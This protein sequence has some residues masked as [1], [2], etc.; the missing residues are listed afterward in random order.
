MRIG[1]FLGN[2]WAIVKENLVA[3]AIATLLMGVIS[4]C[5]L[6]I[7]MGPMYLG[8]FTMCLKGARKEKVEI[9]DVFAGFQ[10]IGDSI[11]LGLI[12]LVAGC[13]GVGTLLL[14]GFTWSYLFMSDKK[15]GFKAAL[16][17]NVEMIKKDWVTT[18]VFPWVVMFIAGLGVI[19]CC[20]GIFVT[21]PVG[22]M[23]ITLFYL[24]LHGGGG[25]S[26]GATPA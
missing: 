11:I 12:L 14:P 25:K 13:T 17:A 15:M 6:Y 24:E 7:L 22:M 1:E 20:V 2:G 5:S 18:L 23:A 4:G 26:A 8:M 10:N 3:Y 9:G 21:A 19:A 16:E